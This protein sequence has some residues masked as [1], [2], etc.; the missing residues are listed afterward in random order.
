MR[1][2]KRKE[3]KL[4]EEIKPNNPVYLKHTDDLRTRCAK[5]WMACGMA[6]DRFGHIDTLTQCLMIYKEQDEA[7]RPTHLHKKGRYYQV[8][9]EGIIEESCTP[10]VIYKNDAGMT[11]IRPA[12]EFYD[13]RFTPIEE[14]ENDDI[15]NE[16]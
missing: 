13:G 9:G 4:V 12:K 8:I 5:M 2:F 3:E 10:A 16:T 14:I 1:W 11:W 15:S 7:F 6:N